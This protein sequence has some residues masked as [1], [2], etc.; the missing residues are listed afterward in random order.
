MTR[1]QVVA[2]ALSVLGFTVYGMPGLIVGCQI[3]V[4]LGVLME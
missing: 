2:V 3:S 1:E 4:A